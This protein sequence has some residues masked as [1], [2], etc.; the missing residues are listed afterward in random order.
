MIEQ[1][2]E[3]TEL[4]QA[5]TIV[6]DK[7]GIT[8]L[9]HDEWKKKQEEERV[10]TN[11]NGIHCNGQ[12]SIV[13]GKNTQRKT[14]NAVGLSLPCAEFDMCHKCQSAKAVD[15]V[16]SI[17]KLISF[18][19]VLKE[20]LDQYTDVKAEV[21]EK[22]AAFEFILDEASNDVYD[23]AMSL[24]NKNGRHP[25]VPMEHAILALCR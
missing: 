7:L 25:R 10:K 22:I 23:G 3:D 19:D 8:M 1:L 15:E 18:I 20:S 17:Y 5:K 6:A 21:H 16:Q 4:E 13:G 9:T 12:Q 24:F 11:P 2:N 14:N